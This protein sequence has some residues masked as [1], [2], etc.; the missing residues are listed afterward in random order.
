[1]PIRPLALIESIRGRLYDFGGDRGAPS[2][3]RYARWQEDD[4]PCLW[5]N[6]ELVGYVKRALRDV[7][8][9]APPENEGTRADFV[10]SDCRKRVSAG[11]PE[12]ALSAGIMAV[13]Q[14][15]LLSS[16]ALLVK[17]E[18]ARLAA[19]RGGDAWATETG[20]PTHYLEPASG[21]LRLYPIPVAA[22]EL[23]LSVR[24]RFAAD[25]E[26]ADLA[27]ESEPSFEL[28][29]VPDDLEEALIVSV[30]RYAYLKR[31]S[32][33]YNPNASRECE[34]MLTDLLG[35]PVSWRQKEARRHNANLHTAIRPA[36][37]RRNRDTRFEDR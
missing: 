6:A 23:R 4:S 16:G 15:R 27:S 10:G 24:R 12:V 37:P 28:G 35:P 22:D 2:A 26:W 32:E 9:R 17:T 25:F 29:D 33:T 19:S 7:A 11:N 8:D 3:G 5:K 36:M 34:R 20:V 13:E 1:M 21:L 30:C 31:D 14:V 18:S